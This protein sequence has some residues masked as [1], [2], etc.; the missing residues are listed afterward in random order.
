MTAPSVCSIQSGKALIGQS[1]VEDDYIQ[2]ARSIARY[3]VVCV[4][5][6]IFPGRETSIEMKL[7]SRVPVN[8]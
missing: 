4:V 3:K 8:G 1:S 5:N 2:L 7:D 6:S